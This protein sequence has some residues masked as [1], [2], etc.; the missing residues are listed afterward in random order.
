MRTPVAKRAHPYRRPST[1]GALRSRTLVM[2][3]AVVEVVGVRQVTLGQVWLQIQR[4]LYRHISQGALQWAGIEQE[5]EE[6]VC[7]SG[8]AIGERELWIEPDSLFEKTDRVDQRVLASKAR[9]SL[10][11]DQSLL[12]PQLEIIGLESSRL[13]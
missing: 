10:S 13:G 11:A 12:C 1:P 3:I 5:I 7:L 4:A 8:C 6:V 9:R 2:I